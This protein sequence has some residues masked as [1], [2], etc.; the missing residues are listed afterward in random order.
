MKKLFIIP[1]LLISL[2]TLSPVTSASTFF[3]DVS[4]NHDA[5]EAIT[6][7]HQME[8]VR[9]YEDGTLKP[10]GN[11]L[12]AEAATIIFKMTEQN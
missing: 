5:F 4:A 9:G 6:W 1:V 10:D 8:F 12:R 11:V 7:A 3:S 2:F